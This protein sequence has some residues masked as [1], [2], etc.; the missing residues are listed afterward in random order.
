M[1]RAGFVDRP[2]LVTFWESRSNARMWFFHPEIHTAATRI[3][4][5]M[6][7]TAGKQTS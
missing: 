6:V 1:R 5:S 7:V 3:S 4:G 2:K